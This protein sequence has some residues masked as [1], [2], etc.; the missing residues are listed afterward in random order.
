MGNRA[1]SQTRGK[2]TGWRGEPASVALEVIVMGT[3]G[4][5]CQMWGHI[6]LFQGRYLGFSPLTWEWS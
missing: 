2:L 6:L 3:D 4:V 1:L 5:S